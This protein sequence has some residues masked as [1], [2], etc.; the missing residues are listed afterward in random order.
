ML[1]QKIR[2]EAHLEG[3]KRGGRVEY[4]S[5]SNSSGG[6]ISSSSSGS[7][8]S[9]SIRSSR[10]CYL[11]HAR[12]CVCVDLGARV[13]LRV[14][15]RV[16]GHYRRKRGKNETRKEWQDRTCDVN[17]SLCN[18]ITSFVFYLSVCVCVCV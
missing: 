11:R 4:S 2:K 17:S 7:S 10:K 9:I 15:V 5:S 13:C 6:S 14:C 8:S 12:A 3:G 16:D 18:I 1:Y